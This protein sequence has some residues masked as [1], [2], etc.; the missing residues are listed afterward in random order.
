MMRYL[1]LRTS[2]R[3]PWISVGWASLIAVAPVGCASDSVFEGEPVVAP[4]VAEFDRSASANRAIHGGALRLALDVTDRFVGIDSV[5]VRYSGALSG[6]FTR[7]YA[8]APNQVRIDTTL[9]VPFGMQG[10][11]V[12]VAQALNRHGAATQADTLT[13]LVVRE[14]TIR[15]TAV[16]QQIAVAPRVELGD[17]VRVRVRAEDDPHG[18]GI[19]RL[20]VLVRDELFPASAPTTVTHQLPAPADSAEHE[21]RVPVTQ[22]PGP[23]TGRER[24][25]TFVAFAIDQAGNC[26]AVGAAGTPVPCTVAAGLPVLAGIAGAPSTITVTETRTFRQAALTAAAGVG[27][28]VVDVGRR[29]LYFTNQSLNSVDALSWDGPALTRTGRAAVGAL[30]RGLTMDNSGMQLI[31]ANSGGTSLSYVALAGDF[32]ETSRYE[33]PNAALWQITGVVEVDTVIVNGVPEER[34]RVGEVAEFTQFSDRPQFVGQDAFGAVF[35]STPGAVRWVETG[36]GWPSPESGIMLW[37]QVVPDNT[38]GPGRDPERCYDDA[39]LE[40]TLPCV[41]AGVDSIKVVAFEQSPFRGTMWEVWAHPVGDPTA[42][43]VVRS[44][45]LHDIETRLNSGGARPFMFAGSWDYSFW[46]TGGNMFVTSSGD[47][48]WVSFADADAGRIWNWG[49]IDGPSFIGGSGPRLYNRRISQFLNIN[50]YELNTQSPFT[51]IATTHDGLAFVSRS[52]TS[53]FFF[54]NPLRLLG[55]YVGADIAGGAGVAIHP[56]ARLGTAAANLYGDWAAAGSAA[57]EIILIETRHF[58]RVGS[59]PLLEPVGGHLRVVQ[60]LATDPGDIVAHIF[61]VTA[62]G[63]VFHVPVRQHHFTPGL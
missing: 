17:T 22:L 23:A 55:S 44:N 32:R 1:P 20:G 53:L 60:R 3:S 38:W 57:P 47:R 19:V 12:F 9:A 29:A 4:P 34:T 18:A 13:A 11:V 21:F 15:P 35:Y 51:A 36:P 33:T 56:V 45:S 52:A 39:T 48:N 63:A 25:L 37:P 43:F 40:D 26:T 41:I 8:G 7:R 14:D 5:M 42:P 27:D 46:E 61:G 50:D 2:N 30:P 28:M 54:T 62:S 59:I 16:T 31:V 10:E 24:Q 49:V 6:E 58:R